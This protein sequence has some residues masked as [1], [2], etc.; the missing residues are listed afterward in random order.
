[1]EPMAGKLAGIRPPLPPQELDYSVK[2]KCHPAETPLCQ[3]DLA[4]DYSKDLSLWGRENYH[5]PD[6]HERCSFIPGPAILLASAWTTTAVIIQTH[7]TRDFWN[8]LDQEMKWSWFNTPCFPGSYPLLALQLCYILFGCLPLDLHSYSSN[9][10]P[11][12]LE[13]PP[14]RPW[15]V[16]RPYITLI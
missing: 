3:C 9:R 7:L 11:L 15:Y 8:K 16:T 6:R 14:I 5:K 4:C 13:S 10:W 1:M 2:G 12:L